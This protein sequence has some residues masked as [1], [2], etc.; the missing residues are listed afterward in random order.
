MAMAMAMESFSVSLSVFLFAIVAMKKTTALRERSAC[1]PHVLER[2]S[3]Y[4][5]SPEIRPRSNPGSASIPPSF[6]FCFVFLFLLC[7]CN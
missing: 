7:S 3:S 4:G 5:R 2:E 6:F 1:F